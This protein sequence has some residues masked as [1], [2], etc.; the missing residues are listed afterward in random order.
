MSHGGRNRPHDRRPERQSLRLRQLRVP[1]K[2][3]LGHRGRGHGA[4]ASPGRGRDSKDVYEMAVA[5]NEKAKMIF[6]AMGRALGV[7]LAN[8]VNIFNFSAV[9]VERRDAAG[10][11]VL[12]PTMIE[13]TRKRPLL[14]ATRPRESTRPCWA[15]SR[16]VRRGL[17]AVAG[18]QIQFISRKRGIAMYWLGIDIGT[19]GTRGAAGRR[20]RQGGG[21]LHRGPRRDAD[22]TAAVGRATPGELVG[23]RPG[24]HPRRAGKANASGADVL[25]IGLRA[26]CTGW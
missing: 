17:P 12:R 26:R 20:R 4:N 23:R 2:A 7:A 24:G 15:T 3:R 14:I 5:G 13:E 1:G 21:G 8:L 16:P 22:G 6:Q 19:G 9:S 18:E 11:G 10:L 25:G